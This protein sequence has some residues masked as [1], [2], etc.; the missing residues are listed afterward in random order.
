MKRGTTK[1]MGL[2]IALLAAAMPFQANAQEG[3]FHI[4]VV[5]HIFYKESSRPF[6]LSTKTAPLPASRY[7]LQ[8]NTHL[9]QT[10]MSTI[11]FPIQ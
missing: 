5:P 10:S 3:F 8:S 9:T 1:W 2:G 11:F 4:P 7:E 6:L